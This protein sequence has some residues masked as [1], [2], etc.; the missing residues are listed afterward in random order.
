[1]SFFSNASGV[2]IL[3]GNFYS[4]AQGINIQNNLQLAI[5][6][7]ESHRLVGVGAAA[8][9]PEGQDGAQAMI[10]N[11]P[12]AGPQSSG[13]YAPETEWS[14]PYAVSEMLRRNI[15]LRNGFLPPTHAIMP[16]GAI[17]SQPYMFPEGSSNLAPPDVVGHLYPPIPQ[18]HPEL[19]L[20]DPGRVPGRFRRLYMP[21]GAIHSQPYMFPEGSS[22]LAPPDV[23][24]HLY[25]PIPQPHPEL[26]LLDP[27][28]VPGRFRRLYTPDPSRLPL[29][30]QV[31]KAIGASPPGGSEQASRWHSTH[32]HATPGNLDAP[33]RP[34]TAVT[35]IHGGS[36][37][38]GNVNNIVRKGESGIGILHR[39]VALAALH[40]SAESYPQPRCHPET[41]KTLLDELWTWCANDSI[42]DWVTEHSG[43][44][45][46]DDSGD[47]SHD[48]S[49]DD[50]PILWLYGPAGAGKSAVMITLSERLQG[51][52][53][54]GGTFFFKRGHSSRGN[55]NVLFATIALQLA[56]NIPELNLPISQ[57]VEEDPTIVG[58]SLGV[59][60]RKLIVEPCSTIECS[61]SRTILIDGL[62]ECEGRDVQ[63]AILR[64]LRESLAQAR[65]PF[66]MIIASR[67]EPH[68]REVLQESSF[69]G[70]YRHFNI[71][72]SYQDVRAYLLS[73]FARIHREHKTMAVVPSPWPSPEVI[74]RLVDKSSGYF[75]YASTVIKFIDDKN[76]RPTR[77]LAA[78]EDTPVTHSQSPFAA[79]DTLYTQ[80]LSG[81][82]ENPDLVP[83]LRVICNFS[84]EPW[85]IDELLGLDSG[86]VKLALRGLRSLIRDEKNHKNVNF[87]LTF[88]H[89]SFGDFLN[90][91]S[92]AGDF[93]TGD[94]AGLEDLVRLVLSQLGYMYNDPKKN[95]T[96]RLA[97][98][99]MSKLGTLLKQVPSADLLQLFQSINPDYFDDNYKID[100]DVLLWLGVSIPIPL[101]HQLHLVP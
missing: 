87:G 16:G 60:L 55:A 35:N 46:H 98:S 72:Q 89:A 13:G 94:A 84:L 68:I 23:V 24:G 82:P 36:F 101:N 26:P 42:G 34:H 49:G 41:R 69:V 95:R 3:G 52:Q 48:D 21:G 40:D 83:I 56:I 66:R 12:F 31:V 77:R 61:P 58:R 74:E 45:S 70:L 78:I 59:Q 67:P 2:N 85:Q 9:Q 80:I 37:V 93:Y 15:A 73:E 8:A 14:S 81:T 27:G 53:Q 100:I 44:D 92:R 32:F 33:P 50:A 19:P 57:A 90:D 97:H 25:P 10:E 63:Q 22:N 38:S 47:D 54:L 96:P 99:L 79:L 43:D 51:A 65:L 5:E 75:I 1:M 18:P 4:A 62:D 7:D 88:I 11:R 29:T 6:E 28:C 76:Y 64:V 71:E 17:H 20:L 91:L 39:A 86:D 30:G